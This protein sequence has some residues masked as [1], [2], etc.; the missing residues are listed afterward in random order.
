MQDKYAKNDKP[1]CSDSVTWSL[2]MFDGSIIMVLV[3]VV[4][5]MAKELLHMVISVECTVA[6]RTE[7]GYEPLNE[8]SSKTLDG[9]GFY[10]G[11]I[12]KYDP[13]YGKREWQLEFGEDYSIADFFNN[14]YKQFGISYTVKEICDEDDLG[15]GIDAVIQIENDVN[16]IFCDYSIKLQELVKDF[17]LEDLKLFIVPVFGRG[18]VLRGKTKSYK[19]SI[20]AREGDQHNEP[21]VHVDGKDGRSGSFKLKTSEPFDG[22]SL[23]D[24]EVTD[25]KRLVKKYNSELFDLWWKQSGGISFEKYYSVE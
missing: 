14:I 13:P 6:E 10:E 17:R 8:E 9:F 24:H 18:E 20:R 19:F 23:R 11:G 2:G 25:V 3:T 15:G 21:H 22:Y 4:W 7:D 1:S 16:I 12:S 5:E